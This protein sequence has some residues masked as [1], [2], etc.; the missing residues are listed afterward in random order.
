LSRCLL[1]AG[2]AAGV[3]G[4]VWWTQRSR[5]LSL[6]LTAKGLYNGSQPISLTEAVKLAREAG[7]VIGLVVDTNA[8][9]GDYTA[10]RKLFEREQVQLKVTL[11][12]TP[13][14]AYTTAPE[15]R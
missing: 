7:D 14:R 8:Y 10:I 5:S 1:I 12:A 13:L 15:T 9:D 4:L 6:R 11:P 2:A 3:A